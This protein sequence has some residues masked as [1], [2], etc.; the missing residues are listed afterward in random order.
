[1]LPSYPVGRKPEVEYELMVEEARGE[2]SRSRFSIDGGG[3][4]G[5]GLDPT[6]RD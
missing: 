6:G 3:L 4:L 1:M 5:Y 2:K